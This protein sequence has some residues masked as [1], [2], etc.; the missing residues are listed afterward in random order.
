MY[1][2]VYIIAFGGLQPCLYTMC[3]LNCT[4]NGCGGSISTKN[5][6]DKKQKENGMEVN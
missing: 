3:N 2:Y 6:G 5:N 4:Q 1:T